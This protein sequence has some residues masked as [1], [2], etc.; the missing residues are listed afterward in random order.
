[1]NYFS[2]GYRFFFISSDVACGVSG[3][4]SSQQRRGKWIGLDKL[5]YTRY[6][7]F[8][9]TECFSRAKYP[10]FMFLVSSRDGRKPF[11]LT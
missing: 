9:V 7:S 11:W 1:M 10:W 6:F 5:R 2:Y 3:N 8:V 4:N